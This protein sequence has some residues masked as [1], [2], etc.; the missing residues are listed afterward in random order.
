MRTLIRGAGDFH[1]CERMISLPMPLS[2]SPPSLRKWAAGLRIAVFW[3]FLSDYLL[4]LLW[5]LLPLVSTEL[6]LFPLRTA[7]RRSEYAWLLAANVPTFCVW[8]WAKVHAWLLS[9]CSL[10]LPRRWRLPASCLV[11]FLG[12]ALPT[13]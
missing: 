6:W 5:L 8:F 9:A 2:S 12:L 13:R 4:P 11:S 3:F 1:F 7:R 10:A